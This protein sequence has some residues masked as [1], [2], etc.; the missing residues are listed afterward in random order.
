MHEV[1]VVLTASYIGTSSVSTK[2][3]IYCA[4]TMH[5]T[6]HSTFQLI[7]ILRNH[8]LSKIL[9]VKYLVCNESKQFQ[10]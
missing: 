4:H 1:R 7:P 8:L 6:D 5:N 2:F 3:G 10:H 9:A